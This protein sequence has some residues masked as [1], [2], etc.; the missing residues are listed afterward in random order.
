MHCANLHQP[1]A[2]LVLQHAVTTYSFKLSDFSNYSVSY[3][4]ML[5]LSI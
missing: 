4:L 3:I 1:L 5:T 2:F